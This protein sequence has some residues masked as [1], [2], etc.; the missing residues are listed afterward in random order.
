MKRAVLYMRVSTA[1]QTTDNQAHDLQQ[2]AQQRGLEIVEQ[3]IDHGIS[4]T[5]SRPW[6]RSHDGRRSTRQ[7]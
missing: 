5:R 4:G 7:V 6:A 3:Y 1:D 2:M